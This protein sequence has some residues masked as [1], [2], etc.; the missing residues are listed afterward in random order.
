MLECIRTPFYALRM[1][2][3]SREHSSRDLL[4]PGTRVRQPRA[5]RWFPVVLLGLG[6]CSQAPAPEPPS[7]GPFA[8]EDGEPVA[9]MVSGP[10]DSAA[11]R[12]AE[13][14]NTT[15]VYECADGASFL[16][17]YA[18]DGA[19]LVLPTRTVLLPLVTS[20]SGGKYQGDNILIWSK[21]EEATIEI[22]GLR[23][24][25]C[26]NN[27]ARAAWVRARLTGVDFRA[28]GNEP[29]WTLEIDEGH[30]VVLVTDY[31]QT[32]HA[33]GPPERLAVEDAGR[34]VY[35][36]SNG[37]EELEAVLLDSPCRDDM[38]GEPYPVQVRLVLSGRSYRGCGQWLQGSGGSP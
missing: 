14:W 11:T 12:S 26:V 24:T 10:S 22:D 17:E 33:F 5:C 25:G 16:V 3:E 23:R 6:A 13:I 15:A 21:G 37:Q 18:E 27:K 9:V 30:G 35:Q 20:A 8:K 4:N 19:R 28:L 38:S 2:N 1:T 29:G 7:T 32:R 31:G 34:T 36:V